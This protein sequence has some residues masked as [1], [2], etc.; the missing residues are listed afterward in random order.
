M[1]DLNFQA[2]Q[3]AT[4]SVV[5]AP[6]NEDSN[7]SLSPPAPHA[8]LNSPTPVTLLSSNLSMLTHPLST[9]HILFN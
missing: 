4:Q 5:C 3:S 8:L 7:V 1:Y 6:M 2:Q 9:N